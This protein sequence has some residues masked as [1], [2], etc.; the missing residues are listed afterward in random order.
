MPRLTWETRLG[1]FLVATSVVIYT[2]KFMFLG[3][4]ENTYYYVFNALGFLPINVLLVTLILNQL[5]SIRAK[6]DKLEKLNMVI[7]TF[8]SEVGTNLLVWISDHD[9]NLASIKS[10][11][12]V[13]NDW[14]D[15]DFAEVQ[16]RLS[17]YSYGVE[18]EPA[19]L[20][21]LKDFLMTRR[22]FLLRLLENPMLLEHERFTEVLR[23]VFHLADELERRKNL[24]EIP[25]TDLIHLT[26]DIDRVYQMLIRSWLDYMR[27]LKNNYP[28]LFSLAMRTNPF[29]ET[30]SPVVRE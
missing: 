30:A 9:K 15:R 13:G 17:R 22:D 5:L 10:D 14:S 12:V 1:I 29:D 16:K 8:F 4:P 23:A 27:Y 20:A 19:E 2:I 11:L 28:Y 18:I 26:G 3:D 25:E 24:E 6:R 21:T 7:G